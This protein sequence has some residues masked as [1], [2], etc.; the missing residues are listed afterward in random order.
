MQTF[1]PGF[2]LFML[3]VLT[4]NSAKLLLSKKENRVIQKAKIEKIS[5]FQ[6]GNV[7]SPELLILYCFSYNKETYFGEGFL[8]IDKLLSEWEIL[9][10]DRNGYPVLQT[11]IGEFVSEEHI[12]TFILS[13]TSDLLIEFNTF[14][15]PESKIY[16]SRSRDKTLFQNIDIKF[17][18]S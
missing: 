12:E 7:W 11:E 9:L 15:L 2:L 6:T 1:I 8:R 13:Q 17:P 16:S 10:Y 4:Y 5:L 14:G 3:A 18:W